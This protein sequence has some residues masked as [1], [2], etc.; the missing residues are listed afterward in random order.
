MRRRHAPHTMHVSVWS[1]CSLVVKYNNVIRDARPTNKARAQAG[2]AAS[3]GDTRE[4]VRDIRGMTAP[5][6][7]RR[8]TYITRVRFRGESIHDTAHSTMRRSAGATFSARHGR[9]RLR[10]RA[11]LGARG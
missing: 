2:A 8:Y 7:R 11:A 6:P 9:R 3:D 10:C 1:C 5:E 4:R